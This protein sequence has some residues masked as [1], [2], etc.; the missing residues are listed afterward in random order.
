MATLR[1]QATVG[2]LRKWLQR[3]RE[4][5]T[6]RF[7]FGGLY[8]AGFASYRGY[9]EDLAIG[10]SA[11]PRTVGSLLAE[12]DAILGHEITGYKGGAY[13]V[14]TETRLW[15][16]NWGTASGTMLIGAS[17]GDGPLV[18]LTRYD[19]YPCLEGPK[20]EIWTRPA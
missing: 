6:V 1:T 14:M 2:Q 18:L 15:V 9:Y 13:R 17:R 8:P 12:L 11:D 5:H 16:A 20:W 4:E 19:P 3:Q 7:D 10:F